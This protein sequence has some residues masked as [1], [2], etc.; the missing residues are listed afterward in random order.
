MRRTTADIPMR[1]I[2][3]PRGGRT[4]RVSSIGS[5]QPLPVEHA[6]C[7]DCETPQRHGKRPAFS[8]MNRSDRTFG[9]ALQ[10]I[11]NSSFAV[12]NLFNDFRRK[13]LRK[14]PRLGSSDQKRGGVQSH[15][16]AS[17]ITVSVIQKENCRS[18]Q[19]VARSNPGDCVMGPPRQTTPRT[20]RRSAPLSSPLRCLI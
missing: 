4:A 2:S 11:P 3:S 15:R 10:I 20:T 8:S 13:N 5:L 6:A 9:V 12:S 18:S 19:P 1:C 17:Y 16:N 7:V 14:L